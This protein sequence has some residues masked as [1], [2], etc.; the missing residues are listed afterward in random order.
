MR[1]P[2]PEPASSWGWT[3]TGL[4]TNFNSL[5][6]AFYKKKELCEKVFFFKQ[7]QGLWQLFFEGVVGIPPPPPPWI[8]TPF[9]VLASPQATHE[10][11]L[12]ALEGLSVSSKKP[13]E[14]PGSKKNNIMP[15]KGSLICPHDKSMI[16]L[17]QKMSQ[18]PDLASYGLRTLTTFSVVVAPL[19][20]LRV[21]RRRE[22]IDPI[23][24][25]SVNP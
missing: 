5:V 25:N 10:V 22:Q 8:R 11:R 7:Y 18:C 4:I 3:H 24:L 9:S 13:I 12:R 21:R 20:P 2:G 6:L 14:D 23:L 19:F 1:P 17:Q 16:F 15:K